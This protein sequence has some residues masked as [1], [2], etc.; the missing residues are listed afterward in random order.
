MSIESGG[1]RVLN[2]CLRSAA[3]FPVRATV[4][5]VANKPRKGVI[6]DSVARR[7][8]DQGER[9]GGNRPSQVLRRPQ[10]EVYRLREPI[11]ASR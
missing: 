11:C 2:I 6:L 8:S 10:R 4:M 9:D 5:D 7:E 1:A 3:A